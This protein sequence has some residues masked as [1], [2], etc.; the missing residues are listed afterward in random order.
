MHENETLGIDTFKPEVED[1][2]IVQ[3][4]TNL[5]VSS[6]LKPGEFHLKHRI[7]Q[8]AHTTLCCKFDHK[9]RLRQ[10]A[11]LLIENKW[12]DRFIM[13]CILLNSL[14]MGRYDFESD[15][16]CAYNQGNTHCES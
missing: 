7:V 10:Q 6:K 12:F 9:S 14:V 15:N 11:I 3:S 4:L 13:V 8:R 1:T 16:L 5:N 2:D